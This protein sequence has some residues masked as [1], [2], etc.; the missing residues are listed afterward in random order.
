[1]RALIIIIGLSFSLLARAQLYDAQWALGINESVLDFR[2]TDTVIIYSLPTVES[3]TLTTA[4]IC[5]ES[6]NLLF[7]TNG[8]SICNTQ[9]VLLNGE[10]LNPCLY[11]QADSLD[12][13][14]IQQA[15]LFLPMPGSLRYY[16]LFHFSNDTLQNSRPGTIYSS[17]IDKEGNGGLGEVIQKNVPILQGHI[18]RGGGMT[19]CK[20]A[21]G[22]DYWLIMGAS[23]TNMFYKFLI[24]PNGI[25]G[26]YTQN[27]GPQYPL[28]YDIAYS[29]FSQ[30]GSKFVTGAVEGLVLVM[31]FD[32]C[33]GEFS[34]PVTIFNDASTIPGVAISG[35]AAVEFSPN[36]RFVYVS[37]RIYLVQYDLLSTNIQDSTQLYSEDSTT[38][39]GIHVLQAAPNGKI[40]A[41]TWGG[42]LGAIHVINYPDLK[43]DSADFVY[44]G[45][46]TYSIPSVALPNLINYKLGPLVGSGCDTITAITE[47]RA[48]IQEPRVIPDPADKYAY[49]EMGMQGNYEFDLLNV[50]G[51]VVDRKETRQVDIFN[52][53]SLS[54]GVYF[55]R[56]VDRNSGNEIASRKLVIMH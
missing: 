38:S 40:Y 52:T 24:T 56:V 7:Y 9:N 5:D 29:K 44:G 28:P 32:R 11:T 31:D 27:I 33:S 20:H 36:N 26:P 50:A 8:I 34:N 3:C 14:N 30:D 15:A 18:L 54:A 45:Q 43:G 39:Y 47:V 22:R 6:G 41:S 21:N 49:V 23:V 53:E 51:Q 48:E 19:A 1:M 35:S 12:G 42:G 2:N 25:L 10:G 17:L 37:D 46:P 4:S 55:I 13:L 16:Y